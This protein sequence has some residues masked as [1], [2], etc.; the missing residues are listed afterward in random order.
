MVFDV[1]I[2][3]DQGTVLPSTADAADSDDD[4]GEAD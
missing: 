4:G 1:K 3:A 2:D